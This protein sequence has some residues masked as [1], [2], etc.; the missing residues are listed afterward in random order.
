QERTLFQRLSE[1][2]HPIALFFLIFFKASTILVYILGGILFRDNFILQFITV[3]L[4]SSGDFWNVKNISGR[5]LVGLRWWNE[6]SIKG[7][8]VWVF[9]NCDPSRYINPID[10]KVFWMMIYA[11]PVIWGFLGIICVLKLEFLSLIMVIV[12]LTLNLINCVAYTKCDKFG[13]VNNLRDN[14]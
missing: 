10:S 9:E 14:I 5:L 2:S 6:T 13:K 3:I 12:T 4:L 1:S 8:N 7:E 11:V